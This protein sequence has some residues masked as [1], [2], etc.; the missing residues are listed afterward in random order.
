MTTIDELL[1]NYR[2]IFC[3]SEVEKGEHFERL[4]KNF[5]LTCPV[6]RG[7]FKN[8]WLW[9]NFPHKNQLGG[10]DL[11]IDI[12]AETFENNFIAVQCKFY[13]DNSTVEKKFVD[14]FI[15]NSARK[16]FVD[17][18]EKN[19]SERI[20]ISTTENYSKNALEMMKNQSPEIKILNLENL[21][22]AQVNWSLLDNGF[23]GDNAKIFRNLKDF[24]KI[25]VENA[26]KYFQKNSRGQLIMACGSGKTFTSLKIAEKIF[27]HGKILFLVPS[28]SLLN[29]SIKC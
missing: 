15:S 29:Q 20:W 3:M 11:G 8:V 19:F 12:V 9:K 5:L 22:H 24:Q 2:E 23:F 10:K 16:F 28:I 6:Y 4:M 26:E 18:I 21:R 1:K 14:S 7:K 17:G 25:A 27:P 13:S